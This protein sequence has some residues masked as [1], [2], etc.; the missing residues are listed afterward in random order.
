[1][2]TD[3]VTSPFTNIG[4]WIYGILIGIIIIVIRNMS[5]Y[6]EGTMFAILLMNM[7]APVIDD[8]VLAFKFRKAGK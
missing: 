6:P 7:F 2:V 3:P 8:A 4:K 5:G 1:M